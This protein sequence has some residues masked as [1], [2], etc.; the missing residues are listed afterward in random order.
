VADGIIA[1]L[2]E[3]SATSGVLLPDA[4]L[5]DELA[6]LASFEP[7]HADSMPSNAPNAPP[8]IT[9]LIIM[10]PSKS[11]RSER[12]LIALSIGGNLSAHC[13]VSQI[14]DSGLPHEARA[15]DREARA[16]AR[17]MPVFIGS[18]A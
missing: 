15:A 4:L 14:R 6:L 17:G 3:L 11:H 12:S 7:P 2:P 5:V 8:R 10:S 1:T 16:D 9:C 13:D 18:S